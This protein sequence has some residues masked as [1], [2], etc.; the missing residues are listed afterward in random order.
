[1]IQTPA[2]TAA[3]A[4]QTNTG[5]ASTAP[6]LPAT[7]AAAIPLFPDFTDL[8][9]G[10]EVGI[11]LFLRKLQASG[12]FDSGKAKS[13]GKEGVDQ[14]RRVVD[15]FAGKQLEVDPWAAYRASKL[16]V[17]MQ[18]FEETLQSKTIPST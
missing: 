11:D 13:Q 9:D 3:T 5:P 1:M 16:G 12:T 15:T 17:G 10:M 8:F 7:P 14:Q 18:I 6:A 4:G 2:S